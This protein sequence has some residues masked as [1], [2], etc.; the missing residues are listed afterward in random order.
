VVNTSSNSLHS[1]SYCKPGRHPALAFIT[2]SM[3]YSGCITP[4]GQVGRLTG[5]QRLVYGYLGDV[6]KHASGVGQSLQRH[7]S[8]LCGVHVGEEIRMGG[9]AKQLGEE[10]TGLRCE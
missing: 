2:P 1:H 6:E 3:M 10:S 4:R 5:R 8:G 9:R 7:R